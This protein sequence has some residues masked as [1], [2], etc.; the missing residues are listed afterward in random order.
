M[1]I[2]RCLYPKTSL[3]VRKLDVIDD[4][5]GQDNH[6]DEDLYDEQGGLVGIIRA[7]G[8]LRLIMIFM[9]LTTIMRN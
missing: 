3:F 6:A 1:E 8:G 9:I 4:N 7:P 2:I 5:N